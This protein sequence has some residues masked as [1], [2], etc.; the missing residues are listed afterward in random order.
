[1]RYI[2]GVLVLAWLAA[3]PPAAQGQVVINELRIDQPGTDNDEYFELAG[4]PGAPLDGLTYIVIGD[5][6]GGSGV[7][8]AVV[9]LAGQSFPE[10]G[11][12]LAA[13][14]TLTLGI[15]DLVANLNFENSDNVT[16]LLVAGFTGANGQDLDTNDDGILDI[17]PWTAVVDGIALIEE[18]NPP[19]GTELAYVLD[20]RVGPEGANVPGHVQRCPD[21]DG[22]AMIAAFDPADG[23]D[24]P[25]LPNLCAPVVDPM[26]A[27]IPQIQGAGHISPFVGQLVTTR[28]VV[29]AVD[30]NGFYLQDP[31]GDGSPDTSDALL[32]FTASRPTVSVGDQIEITASVVEFIPG[33]A[34]TNNLSTT[35]L[36]SPVATT[37]LGRA[38]L[39][40]AVVLGAGGRIPPSEII[41]DDAFGVF[42]PASDGIDFFESLEGMRVA[43]QDALTISPTNGFGEIFTVVDGGASATSLSQRGTI[44]ISPR[45]FNPERVQVQVDTGILNIPTPI[46]DV[47]ARLGD[48]IGVVGYNFGNFEVLITEPLGPVTPGALEPARTALRSLGS[49]VRIATFNVLNLDPNDGDGDTDVADGRFDA[50]G[51]II[52]QSLGAPEIIGLQEVQDND[53]GVTSDV[54]AAGVTLQM[55]VDAVVAAGGPRYRFIDNTFIGNGTSGGQPGGNI[56]VAYLYDASRVSL[57]SG[58]VRTIT[59]PVA[60]RSDPLSPF[61]ATRLPLVAEFRDGLATITVVNVHLSSKGGSAPLFGQ[62]QPSTQLQE[63]PTVNGS[64]DARRSQAL[65]VAGFVADVLDADP[66]ANVAALGDFNE[67]E[68][69]SPLAVLG[70]NLMNLTWDL[71][72]DERYTFIFDGNSQS[73]D[74]VLVSRRLAADSRVDIV[75]VNTE[76]ADTDTRASDHD[77]IVAR[78]R[79]RPSL[80]SILSLLGRR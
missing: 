41:D 42:D 5:G 63:I 40:P 58:S 38:P 39:P 12:F 31:D 35:E 77:P 52:A 57:V 11:L 73:L 69:I 49:R 17:V 22:D 68:F 59:D 37:V 61:F 67:F 70:E 78:V 14:A 2:L 32:V 65:A 25:G 47:G 34:A 43:V 79:L 50:I 30:S 54:T 19:T 76:L 33:G 23:E 53:G 29:T 13:E 55:I 74:H 51:R 44:N 46:V 66:D 16:H 7:I 21:P 62:I 56:R 45:D 36:L 60:Q 18:E 71:P 24:T 4:V 6:T 72:E 64:V 8:E 75:H 27:T 3:S 48:V 28:G 10:T 80:R 20:E 15:A 1:M 9:S 26:A